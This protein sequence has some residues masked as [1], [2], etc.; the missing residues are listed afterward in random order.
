MKELD[1]RAGYFRVR[2]ID[3]EK[4]VNFVK[5]RKTYTDL[6]TDWCKQADLNH[7]NMVNKEAKGAG[8]NEMLCITDSSQVILNGL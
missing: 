5:G 6:E 1:P 2:L 4:T 8:D 3:E 7:L